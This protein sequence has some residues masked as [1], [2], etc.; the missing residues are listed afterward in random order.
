[1]SR[2]PSP[3]FVVVMG[4]MVVNYQSCESLMLGEHWPQFVIEIGDILAGDD[5]VYKQI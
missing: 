4:S 3:N 5:A 1:M 2:P